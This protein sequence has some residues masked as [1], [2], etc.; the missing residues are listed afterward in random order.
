MRPA[1]WYE[2]R[3]SRPG[4]A[5]SVVD[6]VLALAPKKLPPRRFQQPPHPQRSRPRSTRRCARRVSGMPVAGRR[7]GKEEAAAASG[8]WCQVRS[9]EDL[10]PFSP[11]EQ[12]LRRR[13]PTARESIGTGAL[14]HR[15]GA[16]GERKN[17]MFGSW[18]ATRVNAVRRKVRC[19]CAQR[20]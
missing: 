1:C 12:H 10:R 6:A 15:A 5:K 14:R 7:S 11:V 4:L 20:K 18:G 13:A 8:N 16:I 2:R 3:A 17:G 19:M 9:T